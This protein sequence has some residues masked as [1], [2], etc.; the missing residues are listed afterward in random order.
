MIIVFIYFLF[1]ISD[2]VRNGQAYFGRHNA[3]CRFFSQI[4]A[5]PFFLVIVEYGVRESDTDF[6]LK[7]PMVAQHPVVAVSHADGVFVALA[8]LCFQPW[9]YAKRQSQA[10]HIETGVGGV[11]AN[12]VRAGVPVVAVFRVYP[13]AWRIVHAERPAEPN[14]VF[15]LYAQMFPFHV[16]CKALRVV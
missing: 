2:K 9:E 16:V 11:Y 1:L 4:Y 15:G 14:A 10:A 12:E 13:A 3:V 5:A 6:R 7:T 8:A